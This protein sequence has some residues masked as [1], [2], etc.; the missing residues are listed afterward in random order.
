MGLTPRILFLLLASGLA[1]AVCAC[2]KVW[3]P[4]S[5]SGYGDTSVPLPGEDEVWTDVTGNVAVGRTRVVGQTSETFMRGYW[6]DGKLIPVKKGDVWQLFWCESTDA[7]TV[8]SPRTPKTIFQA[9]S[10]GAKCGER[11]LQKV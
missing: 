11:D 7:M 5:D 2:S 10:P 6:P 1:A 4:V 8:A 3:V 9:L